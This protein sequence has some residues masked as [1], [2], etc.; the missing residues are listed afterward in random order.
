MIFGGVSNGQFHTSAAP[1]DVDVN[2]DNVKYNPTTHVITITET[3]GETHDINLSDLVD[4]PLC[5]TDGD[6]CIEVERTAD[7]DIIRFVSNGVTLF[8]IDEQALE[9]QIRGE[10]SYQFVDGQ[11]LQSSLGNPA[12]F[13]AGSSPIHPEIAPLALQ[14]NHAGFSYE[15]ANEQVF[16]GI[17]SDITGEKRV[18]EYVKD[19]T[20]TQPREGSHSLNEFASRR[21]VDRKVPSINLTQWAHDTIEAGSS[22]VRTVAEGVALGIDGDTLD[23]QVWDGTYVE[24]NNNITGSRIRERL[25]VDT[26]GSRANGYNISMTDGHWMID[27]GAITPSPASQQYSMEVK[28]DEDLYL[29][30]YPATRD[31]TATATPVNILY[32][33]NAGGTFHEGHVLSAPLASILPPT[34]CPLPIFTELDTVKVN[35]STTVDIIITG[36]YL[37]TVSNITLGGVTVNGITIDNPNQITVNITSPAV[38]AFHDLVITGTCGEITIA[39]ALEVQLSTWL[40]MDDATDFTSAGW[41]ITTGNSVASTADGAQ[42][43]NNVSSWTKMGQTLGYTGTV[44]QT[45]EMVVKRTGTARRAMFGL[46]DAT[47]SIATYPGSNA[48]RRQFTGAWNYGAG[49]NRDYGTQVGEGGTGWSQAHSATASTPAGSYIKYKWFGAGTNGQVCEVW[50]SDAALN[51]VALLSTRTSNKP[52]TPG[53]TLAFSVCMYDAGVSDYA[54]FAMKIT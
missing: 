20:A 37:D 42:F 39:N 34:F 1:G 45:F 13:Q 52:A 35:Q 24:S 40:M 47:V 54:P 28:D 6:T 10:N 7:D 50:Q 31:D 17:R 2:I 15:D 30:N 53:T 32:T 36:Y 29:K 27:T 21:Y 8:E 43:V 23:Q 4:N 25:H 5:D 51:D 9:Y 33:A 14:N 49:V 18:V 22:E 46:H 19:P 11:G 26:L 38:D 48:Y 16:D 12:T 44:G 41:E 3:D